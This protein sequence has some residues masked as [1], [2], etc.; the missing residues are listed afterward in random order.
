MARYAQRILGS[1][2]L[3]PLPRGR[4]VGGLVR[5]LPE[6]IKTSGAYKD[7][8]VPMAPGD[9]PLAPSARRDAVWPHFPAIIKYQIGAA[10]KPRTQSTSVHLCAFYQGYVDHGFPRSSSEAEL[11]GLFW[12]PKG[13]HGAGQIFLYLYCITLH[14]GPINSTCMSSVMSLVS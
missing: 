3:P 4:A 13:E 12:G 5:L 7:L 9:L 8:K 11:H 1:P 6:N 10:A 2:S 14:L